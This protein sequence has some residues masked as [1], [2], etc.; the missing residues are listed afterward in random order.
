MLHRK[1]RVLATI[2]LVAC[3]PLVVALSSA[4]QP[5]TVRLSW[6]RGAG[7]EGCIDAT[8]LSHDVDAR[9][10]R[11]AFGGTPTRSIEGLVL[12]EKNRWIAHLYVRSLDGALIGDRALVSEAADCGALGSAVTLAIALV[13]DPEA[14]FGPV[15]SSASASIA[16]SSASASAAPPVA[17]S[18]PIAI[19]PSTTVPPPL[20][21]APPSSRPLVG[22]ARFGL[23]T[24][25]VPQVAPAAML[26]FA[27]TTT[28]HPRVLAVLVPGT[29]T[30]DGIVAF[31]ITAADVGVCARIA[32]PPNDEFASI[33][34]CGSVMVGVIHSYVYGL[35]P[36]TPGDRPWV[37][38]STGVDGSLRLFGPLRVVFGVEAIW[39]ITRHRFLA[40]GRT[41]PLFRQS[42]VTILGSL[43]LGIAF[44]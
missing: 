7:A 38:A 18:S 1:M 9:L 14:A 37:A 12:R 4:D 44:P 3:A 20:P 5:S 24:G 36:V 35:Q 40:E 43:G 19:A 11:D 29:K 21:I 23:S 16:S 22:Q 13:I 26:G 2:G 41:E 31:G 42:F 28:V 8:T 25:L 6:V 33:A 34:A 39:P 30:D 27:G 32:S 15:A 17:S 10:G